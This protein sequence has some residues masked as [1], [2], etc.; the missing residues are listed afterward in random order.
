VTVACS[1]IG[2]SN[3]IRSLRKYL[4]EETKIQ[5]IID[6]SKVQIFKG[7]VTYPII[8]IAESDFEKDNTFFYHLVENENVFIDSRNHIEYF[9]L[10]QDSLGIDSWSFNDK[11]SVI[12]E[13]ISNFKALREK[14]GKCYYGV[15][16]ALNE[17]FIVNN[18]EIPF[19]EH[20][21]KIFEGKDIKKW[22][23]PEIN[24]K[25]ILFQAGF[26]NKQYSV[27]SEST[28]LKKMIVD[29]PELF[30][31][32]LPFEEQA[33]KRYDQGEYWWELRN[34]AYYDLFAKPKIIFPN[35][36]N[37]N[38]FSFD[39]KGYYI[40]APAVFL[41]TKEKWLLG[42][43]NSKIVWFFLTHICVVRSGGY[44][45]VKPQYFEQIPIPEI[46]DAKKKVLVSLVDQMLQ[47]Q[48]ELHSAKS[49][50]D[51]RIYEQKVNMLDKKI[52]ELVYKLY[53]LTDEEIKIVEGNV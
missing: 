48:I 24:K 5:Q 27:S 41:P 37:S 19:S 46:D 13:K 45:E 32:L 43:L 15:K 34:C 2:T 50:A 25:L 14:F 51:K 31:L 1:Y 39:E 36:Q 9:S 42:I 35:L 30:R 3:K 18:F 44:I 17:A 6:F 52:D 28:L 40:N 10:K 23:T 47:S 26:S 33:K 16:T 29:F 8:F 21:K 4:K 20:V 11:F 38:K 22:F 49:D 53:D 12:I 7:A